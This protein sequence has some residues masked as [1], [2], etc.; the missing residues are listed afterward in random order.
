MSTNYK[1]PIEE[2]LLLSFSTVVVGSAVV[3]SCFVAW[4]ECSRL[5]KNPVIYP[6]SWQQLKD[7]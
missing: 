4:K 3:F 5:I 6:S 2:I 7:L 1:K